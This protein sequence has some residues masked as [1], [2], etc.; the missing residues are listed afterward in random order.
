VNF[1]AG[2]KK[3][4]DHSGQGG[5]LEAVMGKLVYGAITSLDGFIEDDHGNFDWAEPKEDVHRYINDLESGNEIQIYGRKM[6]ETML[7]WESDKNFKDFPE[8]IQEYGKTWQKARKVVY[9]RTL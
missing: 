9:S 6:Y 7:F 4:P 2:L 3:V 1:A 8:Y 5:K